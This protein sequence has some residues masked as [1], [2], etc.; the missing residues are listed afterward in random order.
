MANVKFISPSVDFA[1]T[2]EA[3][4]R[5]GDKGTHTSRTMMLAELTRVLEASPRD[6]KRDDYATAII[7]ENC[8][9]KPTASTRRLTNQRLGELYGLDPAIPIFR[10]FRTLWERNGPDRPLLALLCAI[11]RDP[12][13]A[14]TAE[15]VI[16][17]AHGSDFQREPMRQDLRA[18]VGNRLSDR[19]LDK[20]IRNAASSW[21]QSGHL[22]G[23]SIKRR[24]RV[25]PTAESLSFALY[26]SYLVGFRG[27]ELFSSGWVLVLDCSPG[28]ARDLALEAK[29]RELLDIRMAADILEINFG[30]IEQY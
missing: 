21:T 25:R 4:L 13:L 9:G 23:R 14:T 10:V 15:T 30:R 7:G 16:Q 2:E 5:F 19:T 27:S 8:L 3:G 1:S 12:L 29:R 24:C 18:A 6:A 11:A 20:V 17:L 26:L 28:M 22:E